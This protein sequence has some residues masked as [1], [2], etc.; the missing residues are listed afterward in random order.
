[1]VL[2]VTIQNRI[3]TYVDDKCV[4]VC[5]NDGDKIQ[6]TFDEEWTQHETKTAR[7]KWNGAVFDQKF[8]GEICEIPKINNTDFITVGVFVGEEK[9]GERELSTTDTK[10]PY[11]RSTRCG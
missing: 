2:N 3:A 8:T 10:I 5:G 11:K 6:F 7:F 1:M 9:D 4:P